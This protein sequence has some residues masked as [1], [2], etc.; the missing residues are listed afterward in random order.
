MSASQASRDLS[1][2]SGRIE[3]KWKYP[4]WGKLF[5]CKKTLKDHNRIHTGERP[6]ECVLWGQTFSQYSSLQKHGRVHDKKKPYKCEFKGCEKSFSQISNLIRHKRI[7]TGEK[8]YKW[9]LWSKSFASGSNLK[10][11]IQTHE[12]SEIRETF[13]WKYWV[14]GTNKQY[15]YYSSLRKHIQAY[16]KSEF[17]KIQESS[18]SNEAILKSRKVGGIFLIETYNRMALRHMDRQNLF[19][20]NSMI[21]MS[22]IFNEDESD[23]DVSEEISAINIDDEVKSEQNWWKDQPPLRPKTNWCKGQDSNW[24]KEKSNKC[25]KEQG[26]AQPPH[27]L[28]KLWFEEVKT[29][30]PQVKI[31]SPV[32]RNPSFIMFKPY[33]NIDS[34]SYKNISY[35]NNGS[36]IYPFD[37]LSNLHGLS[38]SSNHRSIAESKFETPKNS[39]PMLVQQK[40]NHRMISR[41]KSAM[42]NPQSLFSSI[43]S[44]MCKNLK[45]YDDYF[46]NSKKKQIKIDYEEDLGESN[47]V[48]PPLKIEPK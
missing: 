28:P 39:V 14:K 25:W 16:H 26:S 43:E 4:K 35:L 45:T 31:V 33:K 5:S 48:I 2:E 41:S 36:M 27:Q 23:L 30:L 10:Q 11:H 17:R 1:V 22:H 38:F 3:Y 32:H 24:G 29:P 37:Q 21:Y 42:F 20:K 12:N 6:Y 40:S 47:F 46:D 7:H 9:D 34:D 13:K 44:H 15:Y 19:N 8:P 18:D